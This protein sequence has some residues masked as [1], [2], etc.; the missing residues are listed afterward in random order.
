MSRNT[1]K[2]TKAFNAK[3]Y[4]ITDMSWTPIGGSPIMSGPEG[5]WYIE[6]DSDSGEFGTIMAYNIQEV[7][8]EITELPDI[9][10]ESN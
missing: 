10:E 9:R 5:G 4:K 7:M 3:G 1:D 6:Y 8:D 2:I